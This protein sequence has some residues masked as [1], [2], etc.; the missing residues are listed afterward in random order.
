M[1]TLRQK[2]ALAQAE[3]FKLQPR[4][5]VQVVWKIEKVKQ[6]RKGSRT[7]TYWVACWR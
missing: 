4:Q 2:A 7:Y 5:E 3:A 6:T 1:R